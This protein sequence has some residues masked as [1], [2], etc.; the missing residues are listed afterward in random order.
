MCL[1]ELCAGDDAADEED[2]NG[3]WCLALGDDV[4]SRGEFSLLVFFVRI[5]DGSGEGNMIF[6]FIFGGD[7]V[8]GN[9]GDTGKSICCDEGVLFLGDLLR[10]IG[11]KFESESSLSFL[12]LGACDVANKKDSCLLN[13]HA[14]H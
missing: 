13:M 7:D 12:L 5:G 1:L 4:H 14:Y 3:L 11:D 2:V 6:F 10:N 9:K 8:S